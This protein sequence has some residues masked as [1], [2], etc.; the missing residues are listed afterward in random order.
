MDHFY[1][2]VYNVAL[3]QSQRLKYVRILLSFSGISIK[4]NKKQ[5]N[6]PLLFYNSNP[7]FSK[8]TSANAL[9]ELCIKTILRNSRSLWEYAQ[10]VFVCLLVIVS[11]PGSV[12]W[13]IWLVLAFIMVNYVALYWKEITN[14]DFVQM[15]KWKREDKILALQKFLFLITLP[16]FLLISI[17]MGIQVLSWVGAI[18]IVPMSIIILFYTCRIMGLILH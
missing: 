5:R 10:I 12:K 3:E 13:I 15:F 7:I 2:S 14:S 8:R 17:V 16:G 4:T 18:F 6:R 1:S 11:V 9:V